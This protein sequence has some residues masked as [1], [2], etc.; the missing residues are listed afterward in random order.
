MS[1]I[2]GQR[3][4]RLVQNRNCLAGW[5]SGLLMQRAKE[6]P[7]DPSTSE[8]PAP[9]NSEAGLLLAVSENHVLRKLDIGQQACPNDQ[10]YQHYLA[11]A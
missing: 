10:P 8:E 1:L 2:I 11:S 9:V 6:L 3:F 4:Q 7:G 5:P